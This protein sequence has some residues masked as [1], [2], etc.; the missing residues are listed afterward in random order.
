M[1]K[2]TK[3]SA[4]NLSRLT[5]TLTRKQAHRIHV[6]Q[7]VATSTRAA[8]ILDEA[9][10]AAKPRRNNSK[11]LSSVQFLFLL[12]LSISA[13]KRGQVTAMADTSNSLPAN[14][15]KVMGL[16]QELSVMT[17]Y[18]YTKDIGAAL[19]HSE[20]RTPG[21]T[22]EQRALRRNRLDEFVTEYLS[23]TV[24]R[25]E[26]DHLRFAID[27]TAVH[28]PERTQSKPRIDA[29]DYENDPELTLG[30]TPENPIVSISRRGSKGVS[31]ASWR[32]KTRTSVSGSKKMEWFH[33]YFA[34]AIAS[35]PM[36]EAGESDRCQ[37]FTFTLT[38]AKQDMF[39]ASIRAIDKVHQRYGMT[40]LI[41][42]RYYSN[43]VYDKWWSA[44]DERGINPV[45]DLS[46]NQQGFKDFDGLKIA[47]AWPHCPGTPNELGNIPTLPPQPTP[48]ERSD[49]NQLIEERQKY[50]L[51]VNKS[52]TKNKG[53]YV[54]PAIQGRV[55]CKLRSQSLL[56]AGN[57]EGLTIVQNPPQ[58]PHLPTCCTE[59]THQ[60]KIV[61]PEQKIAFR[62]HQKVYWGSL[63]WQELYKQR[64]S[65]ERLFGYAKRSYRL[66]RN[67][68]EFRGFGL[69]TVVLTTLF[70]EINVQKLQLWA[71]NQ[72]QA[73]T[74]PTLENPYMDEE[75]N[76]A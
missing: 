75:K 20:A 27:A 72:E 30:L 11:G 52:F 14:I 36:E 5:T 38:S 74:H 2:N 1:K 40:D 9:L 3:A 66:D 31:D 67:T 71:Q 42:D 60:I 22:D 44:L 23:A 63:K 19:D 6:A 59:S 55:A 28:A 16:P 29:D 13:S 18:K 68:F 46:R 41:G 12:Q 45:N 10:T 76:V 32:G 17:V 4:S 21:L 37:I 64:S 33:G 70:A 35:A 54:C 48:Q 43:L 58:G 56:N 7:H 53:R 50:A 26:G 69:S 34:N 8:L 39:I 25:E 51:G 24:Y 49:F 15:K 73:I 61:T 62:N 47:A 65:I 57:E